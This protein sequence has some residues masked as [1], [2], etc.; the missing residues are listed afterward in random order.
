MYFL[1]SNELDSPLL[2]FF[3]SFL[4]GFCGWV[5]ARRGCLASSIMWTLQMTTS[6]C[7]HGLLY[8]F[9]EDNMICNGKRH[10]KLIDRV[11]FVD[12]AVVHFEVP[13]AILCAISM[14]RAFAMAVFCGALQCSVYF[15]LNVKYKRGNGYIQHAVLHVNG[16]VG[17]LFITEACA[18]V[19][20][21]L[22]RNPIPSEIFFFTDFH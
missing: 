3:T 9:D 4:L 22:C 13:F 18:H 7:Y 8:I 20:C 5:A 16:A 12:M 14:S 15:V 21:L 6:L 10:M 17:M 2:T 11:R 19:E 1:S